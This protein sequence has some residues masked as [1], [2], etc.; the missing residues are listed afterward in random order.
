MI[1]QLR[2]ANR[3]KNRFLQLLIQLFSINPIIFYVRKRFLPPR[4]E[5][6]IKIKIPPVMIQSDVFNI[7]INFFDIFPSPIHSGKFAVGFIFIADIIARLSV[8]FVITLNSQINGRKRFSAVY[9]QKKI[10]SFG[11]SLGLWQQIK[12]LIFESSKLSFPIFQ[13]PFNHII[14]IV[15]FIFRQTAAENGFFFPVGQSFVFPVQSIVFFVINRIKRFR[16]IV[17]FR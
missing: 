2:P 15:I 12:I 14:H 4:D 7:G 9:R 3:G 1:C 13:A 6:M 10:P 17:S 5:N 11:N 8:D 16:S